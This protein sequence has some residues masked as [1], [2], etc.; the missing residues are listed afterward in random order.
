MPVH[1]ISKK[2]NPLKLNP[3]MIKKIQHSV[4][5]TIPK[6]QVNTPHFIGLVTKDGKRLFGFCSKKE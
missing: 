2:I 4:S 5:L 1:L 6:R 3:K